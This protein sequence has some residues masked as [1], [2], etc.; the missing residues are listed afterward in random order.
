MGDRAPFIGVWQG[1]MLL[2]LAARALAVVDAF[3][4]GDFPTHSLT[5]EAIRTA[6]TTGLILVALAGVYTA[7]RGGASDRW[8]SISITA[9]GGLMAIAG[10]LRTLPPSPLI[11]LIHPIL[12][13]ILAAHMH[14]ALSHR[15]AGVPL[16][17]SG[18][19]VAGGTIL[20][21]IAGSLQGVLALTDLNP[22]IAGTGLTEVGDL[23]WSAAILHWLLG[24]GAASSGSKYGER[25]VGLIPFWLTFFGTIALTGALL[26]AGVVQVYSERLIGLS[27]AESQQLI[28]PLYNAAAIAGGILTLGIAGYAVSFA[29]R[30]ERGIPMPSTTQAL[31]PSR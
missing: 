30:A 21:L 28:A 26:L 23:L 1:G 25:V 19:W 17:Y 12:V 8:L 29:A 2:L 20:F 7:L 11:A 10:A 27:F 6:S 5:I 22:L 24:C 15:A 14:Y 31:Q 18:H 13:A 16:T 4:P 3:S 9:T